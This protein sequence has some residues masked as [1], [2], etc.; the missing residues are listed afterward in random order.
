MMSRLLF[1]ALLGGCSWGA[2]AQ[3]P[4]ADQLSLNELLALTK[5]HTEAKSLADFAQGHPVAMV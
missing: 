1:V 4:S 2:Q 3:L 5:I